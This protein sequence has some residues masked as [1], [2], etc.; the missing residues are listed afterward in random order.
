M[1][2]H[3]NQKS[4]APV[5]MDRTMLGEILPNRFRRPTKPKFVRHDFLPPLR[6]T[7]SKNFNAEIPPL[8]GTG[9]QFANP[10]LS[11]D[12]GRMHQALWRDLGSK[13]NS[14]LPS[15]FFLCLYSP[16]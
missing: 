5:R 13:T 9:K 2:S 10:M 3:P 6:G 7:Q 4:L 1:W 15:L 11:R 8:V 12:E 16:L 14:A